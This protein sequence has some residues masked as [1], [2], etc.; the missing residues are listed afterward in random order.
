MM[1]REITA[2]GGVRTAPA[3]KQKKTRGRGAP[4]HRGGRGWKIAWLIFSIVFLIWVLFPFLIV[5]ITSFTT[6][7]ELMSTMDFIWFPKETT[8][9]NYLVFFQEDPLSVDGV[10]SILRGFFNTMWMTLLST[11]VSLF[12]SGLAAYA[13]AKLRFPGKEVFFMLQIVTMMIPTAC[14]T[15]PSYL[16]YEMIGWT[17]TPLPIIIPAMFG[18]AS[19]IFF[20]RGYFAGISSEIVEAAKIDGLGDFRIYVKMIMPLGI[21]AMMAQFI[22]LFITGYNNYMGPLLYLQQEEQ[23]TLQLALSML[24]TIFSDANQKCAAIVIA[25]VPILIVYA[26]CQRFIIAG[27]TVGGGKE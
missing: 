21:P 25:L 14:M 2:E 24:Q 23:Y 19:T 16:F 4:A 15:M 26:F 27:I 20:L 10:P 11:V 12:L 13:Y 6:Y 3:Q 18:S 8:F 5:V 22:F 1:Q 17:G 7:Q 9:E